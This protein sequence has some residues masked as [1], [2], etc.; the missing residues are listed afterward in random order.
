M[1]ATY[2][3]SIVTEV[4][5]YAELQ[6]QMHNALIVQHPEWIEDNGDCPK[7]DDYD[8]RFAQLLGLSLTMR[9]R[10]R[11]SLAQQDHHA[12]RLC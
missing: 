10:S 7:C 3:S 8:R 6:S 11:D 1:N 12:R 9:S 5:A 2:S 4:P